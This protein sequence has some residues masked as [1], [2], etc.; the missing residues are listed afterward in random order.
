MSITAIKTDNAPAAVGPYS[1]GIIVNGMIF[2]AG[3]AGLVPGTG[4]LIEGGIREQ[5]MQTLR[6]IQGVLEAGGASLNRVVKTTVFLQN[7]ADFPAMNEVYATFFGDQL[8]AR[9]TVEVAKLPLGA[10]VEIEAIALIG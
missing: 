6:N 1:Q 4:K 2:T 8:P 10:L 9:S 5:T 7:M 3:Q